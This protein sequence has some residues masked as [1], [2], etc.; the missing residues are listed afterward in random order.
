MNTSISHQRLH[1][2]D[3]FRGFTMAAMVIVN[4]PGSWSAIYGPLRHAEWIGCTPTDLI[5]PFFL[6]IVG[7]SLELTRTRSSGVVEWHK[8]LRR[9]ATLFTLGLLLAA[10]P[11]PGF[12]HIRIPGVL[13]RIALCSI[14]ALCIVS[15]VSLRTQ[16][17]IALF[18]LFGYGW[19]LLTPPAGALPF[20][21]ENNWVRTIDLALLGEGHV[22]S[23]SPTDPEGV[24]STLPAIVT[25]L[26]G[27]WAMRALNHGVSPSKLAG[28]G[29]AAIVVSIAMG[30]AMPISKPL[31]TP[32]YVVY[33]AGLAMIVL[34]AWI[35]IADRRDIAVLWKPFAMLGRNAIFLFVGSGLLGRAL[36]TLKLDDGSSLKEHAYAYMSATGLNPEAASLLYACAMLA[37]WSLILW[38]MHR[39]RMYL[40]L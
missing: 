5:F 30:F 20:D 11:W 37:L 34:A 28:F 7:C 39:K 25:V 6:F 15:Q 26:S 24:L 10:F 18:M 29:V 9:T 13:Q 23:N 35:W 40:A 3:A 27:V 36:V 14:A 8:T 38:M 4:N 16:I 19:I 2:L 21:P 32:T 12:D 22:Y 1:S 31:W 33:T 17:G